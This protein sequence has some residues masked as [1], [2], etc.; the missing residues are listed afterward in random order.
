M[1]NL[2]SIKIKSNTRAAMFLGKAE[3]LWRTLPEH[4]ELPDWAQERLAVLSLLQSDKYMACLSIG[5]VE[6]T[7]STGAINT[8]TINVPLEYADMWS[9][10]L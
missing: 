5:S 9:E 7:P 3:V 6:F 8:V 2:L 4:Y 1:S 10:L